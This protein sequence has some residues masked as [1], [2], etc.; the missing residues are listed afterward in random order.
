MVEINQFPI[1]IIKL[2]ETINVKFLKKNLI[3]NLK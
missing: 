3:N 2:I 1:D